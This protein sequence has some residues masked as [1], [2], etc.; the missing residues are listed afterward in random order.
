MH[1]VTIDPVTRIEGHLKIEVE[2]ENG[3]VV[4]AQSSGAM[5]RGIETILAGR[6]PVDAHVLTS[7]VC[8]VCPV[9]HAQAAVLCADE[10][11]KIAPPDNGRIL[12]N[13]IQAGNNLMSHILHFYH[14]TAL[15]Y[16]TGPDTPPFIPRYKG[17]YR[18]PKEINDKAVEQYIQALDIRMKAHEMLAIFGGRVPGLC[19]TVPGGATETVTVDK[20][21]DFLWR[22][23]E[24]KS[25]IENSYLPTVIAVAKVYPDYWNIGVGCKNLLSYGV[26]PDASGKKLI[27]A[28]VFSDGKDEEFDHAKI[29]EHVKY[30]WYNDDNGG[31]HPSKGKTT[32]S[33]DKPGAYSWLKA[34]RYDNKVYEVG[35]LAR[36]FINRK[37]DP[38]L[39]NTMETLGMTESKV[40]SVLGR[41]AAR[42]VESKICADAMEKW[43][44]ELKPGKPAHTPYT[45]PKE[46]EGKGLTEAS[47]G[48]LGHWM[49]I[50]NGKVALYQMIVPTTWNGSPRDDNGQPGPI[51]QALI[52][53]PVKDDNNPIEL[54][55]VVRSFDPCISCAVHI[56]DA[57]KKQKIFKV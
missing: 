43:V 11:F 8:G 20:I 57:D 31:L 45:V 18:L 48:A 53:T 35:P 41:H 28:G 5:H 32:P 42:A 49:R 24:I 21:T 51:E 13:L 38:V 16:V 47:R 22:L 50:E 34:P 2:I 37:Q 6:D 12:R 9:S 23:K 30:A 29:T 17:D 4:H 14:L 44:M 10:A 7:R 52:G 36:M 27:N 56:L 26:Y 55:R 25:F 46:G 19:G 40:F 1:K 3:K 33:L 39:V 54:V 15:D